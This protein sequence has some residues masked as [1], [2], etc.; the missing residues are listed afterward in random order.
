LASLN[1]A[2][3]DL[4]SLF[5]VSY[6]VNLPFCPQAP[7]TTQGVLQLAAWNVVAPE[8]FRATNSIP[9]GSAVDAGNPSIAP[10]G[11]GSTPPPITTFPVTGSTL[12][13]LLPNLKPLAFISSSKSS[14]GSAAAA[15]Q[16]YDNNADAFLSAVASGF[17]DSGGQPDNLFLF[18]D[19]PRDI[20]N[21]SLPGQ[22]IAK[23]SLPLVVL[24]GYVPPPGT[25]TPTETLVPTTLQIV[26]P[27]KPSTPGSGVAVDCSAS[28]V[29][30]K[31][32]SGSAVFSSLP[33][34]QIG[35]D[36]AVVFA[37]SPTAMWSHAIFEVRVPLVV[38]AA[39]DPLYIPTAAN[40]GF[41][42][43]IANIGTRFT[44][45]VVPASS[46]WGS[47]SG[48]IG[49][50]PNAAPLCPSTTVAI[51]DTPCQQPAYPLCAS[52]P[53]L[54]GGPVPAVAAY[55]AMSTAGETLLSAALP[56]STTSVCPF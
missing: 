26:V 37:P 4:C 51:G 32:L 18:Y 39:T 13:N 28:T 43:P 5:E 24:T 8:M 11:F 27:K 19:D 17:K 9:L 33:A 45:D 14:A 22:V 21:I 34:S 2:L 12:S 29:S 1:S 47:S 48:S 30:G 56:G 41:S 53:G 7:T 54:L 16:L 40:M 23:I 38:T 31:T 25:S 35:I 52:L 50:G 42:N 49:I 46:S 36:C 3:D 15:T 20:I 6:S 44:G 10:P 55:Y